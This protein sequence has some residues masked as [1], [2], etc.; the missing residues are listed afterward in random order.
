MFIIEDILIMHIS[1][2]S[3]SFDE[4]V[5]FLFND[6][7]HSHR[8]FLKYWYWS[9]TTITLIW[10]CYD[11]SDVITNTIGTCIGVYFYQIYLRKMNNAK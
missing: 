5:S 2:V 8:T 7:S 4:E 9:L 10:S 1:K 3:K 6:D 11:I